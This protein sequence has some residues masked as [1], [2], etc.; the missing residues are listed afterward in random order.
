MSGF[1]LA[2]H[3]KPVREAIERYRRLLDD[4]TVTEVDDNMQ[5]YET[6][7][8]QAIVSYFG[9]KQDDYAITGSTTMGLGTVYCGLKLQAPQEV[10]STLHDHYATSAS[11]KIASARAGFGFRRISLYANSALASVEEIM[12][13][14]TKNIRPETRVLA[15][16]WVHSST[17][18]KLPVARI[19]MMVRQINLQ[20]AENDKLILAVDGV[21][22]FGIENTTIEELGCDFFM[23]GCH[24]WIFGPR[25]TGLVYGSPTAW[26]ITSPTIPSFDAIWR[27]D[28][29]ATTPAAM[30]TP[31][32]FHAFEHVWALPA[33]FQMH[34]RI[35][36]QN[37][38]ERT[39]KLNQELKE[40]L[41]RMQHV[42]L[43]TPLSEELSAG[44]VCFD[45]ADLTPKQVV[46]RLRSMNV[47]ATQT[48]YNVSYARVSASLL[49]SDADI[50]T[51]VSAVRR[52]A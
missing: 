44:L 1:F 51:T 18:V 25:G 29:G 48:P 35:G 30:M 11:L 21:H 10:L 27:G 38:Y 22:G 2:S 17:G 50:E 34:L 36:K 46:A 33:A 23:A 20:R 7:I 37:V 12:E 6:Q 3:P 5:R 24:K 14:L 45:V 28:T 40:G 8:R 43:Y 39:V 32:G 4:C 49:N 52:L 16:T 15:I 26:A 9:G 19:S 47:I 31:G 42:K 41:S 13:N